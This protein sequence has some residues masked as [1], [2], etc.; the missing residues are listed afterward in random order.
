MITLPENSEMILNGI[1]GILVLILCIQG[2]RKGLLRS[3]LSFVSTIACYYIAWVVSSSLSTYFPIIQL[4]MITSYFDN[5]LLQMTSLSNSLHTLINRIIWFI[6][7]FF[8]LK[9]LCLF[10]DRIL[11]QLHDIPVIHGISGLLGIVFG[12]TESIVWIIILAIVLETP[13]FT[14]GKEVVEHSVVSP[15]KEVSMNIFSSF[16]GPLTITDTISNLEE[17]ITSFT[18]EQLQQLQNYLEINGDSNEY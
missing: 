9:I 4:E 14:G 17:N 18:D 2:Y 16:A 5:T 1:V 7:M 10:L 15:I 12:L 3:I 8:V 11:K 13:I 6:I